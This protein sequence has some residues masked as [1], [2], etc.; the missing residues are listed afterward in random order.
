[1][2]GL[3]PAIHVLRSVLKPALIFDLNVL[4]LFLMLL[5]IV[6]IHHCYLT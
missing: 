3:V 4:Y 6:N 1:M 5:A 2:A